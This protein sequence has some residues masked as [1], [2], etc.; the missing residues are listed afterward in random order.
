MGAIAAGPSELLAAAIGGHAA[1]GFVPPMVDSSRPTVSFTA[2][3]SWFLRV[4]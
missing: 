4:K 2:R 3:R 1:N